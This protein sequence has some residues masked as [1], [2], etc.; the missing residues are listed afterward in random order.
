[1]TLADATVAF[2]AY[3]EGHRRD[4]DD[5]ELFE[6]LCRARA[7]LEVAWLRHVSEVAS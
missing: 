2:Q 5:E 4:P 7:V 3:L 1:M 6:D